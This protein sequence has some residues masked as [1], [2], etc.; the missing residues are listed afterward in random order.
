MKKSELTKIIRQLIKENYTT[1]IHAGGTE[2]DYK[3][4]NN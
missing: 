1:D 3:S 2:G 4:S